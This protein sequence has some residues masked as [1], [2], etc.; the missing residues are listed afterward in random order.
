MSALRIDPDATSSRLNLPTDST[1]QHD[2]LRSLIAGSTDRAVYHR[3]AL[4]HLHSNGA[5]IRLPV[6]P[7][8]WALACTWRGLNLPY[9][10]YGPVIVTG[11]DTSGAIEDLNDRLLT[12]AEKVA[13][14]ALELRLEWSA[15]P[16]VSEPAAQN[17]LLAYARRALRPS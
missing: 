2:V 17:E 1:A 10:L 16:P 12:E 11:P 5:G 9:L 8:A 14:K 6:N 4:L 15:R 3:Q 13:D 7:A